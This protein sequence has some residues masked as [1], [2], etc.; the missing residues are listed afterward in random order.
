MSTTDFDVDEVISKATIVEKLKLLAGKDAWHTY[1][2][3]SLGV[4]SIRFT[5]GPNGARGTRFVSGVPA[6]CVPC[7][8][9][10]GATWDQE[11]IYL[12]G[13]L[14]GEEV[15]AK[16]ARGWLGPTV[17]I[18][19]SPLGGR[20]FESFAEDPYLSGKIAASYINGAQSTGIVSTLKHFVANELEHER[21]AVD[22]RVSDRALREIYLLPFQIAIKDASPAAIMTAYNKVN[23]THVSEDSWLL[24]DVLRKDW[25]FKGMIMSDWYGTYSTTE[26][27]NA[28]LD[29]EM[30]GPSRW[31]GDIANLAISSRKITHSTIDAR[32][33][34]VLNLVK[35]C[36]KAEGVSAEEGKRDTPENRALN[37][38]L[39]AEGIV[40]LK[41]D[42]NILPLPDDI[43]EIALI[44][45][46]L[47]NMAYCGGGSAQLEP[48]YIVSNYEGIV[49]QLT[50]QGTRKDVQIHYEIGAHAYDYLPLLGDNVT[51]PSGQKG[52]LQMRFFNEPVSST[53]REIIDELD[54]HDSAW[55]LMGYSSSRLNDRFWADIQGTFTPTETATFQWGIACYGTASL[56]VDDKLVI[57]NT[58]TQRPGNSF[59]GKGTAE[60]RHLIEMVAGKAYKIRVEYGNALTTKV[61][62]PGV[63]NYGGG[64]GRIGAVAI[65]D[66][67][68]AIN[69]AVMLAERCKYTILC[70]GLDKEWE[71][72]GFDRSTMDLP[73]PMP[74]LIQSVLDVNPNTIVVT[75]S[76]T[77]INM[78]PWV[79]TTTTQVH[80]WYGGNEVGNGLAD[81]LFGKVNPSGKL[82]MSFPNA[83]EDTPSFLNFE[84]QRGR[85]IYGEDIYVGYRYYEKLKK[86]LAFPFGHGLS[87]TTFN[88]SNLHVTRQ[89]ATFRIRNSGSTDGATV[90]QLYVSPS[91]SNS[92]SRPVKELKGFIKVFLRRGEEK[93][94][95]IPIDRLATSF[96]DE[97]IGAWV[98]EQGTYGVLVGESSVN[99]C[100]K[101]LL[102]VG[103]T[104]TWSGL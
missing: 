54:L 11:L 43:T 24:E 102:D 65:R 21:M 92:I 9:A 94:V 1:D 104:M 61:L 79:S 56:Y 93:D 13:Q 10:L 89:S 20:G 18:Q 34:N 14:I 22:V 7:G 86:S 60:E 17:N 72:E 44:G 77:P 38:R 67:Q 98:S 95:S 42:N 16:G 76:G 53:N 46:S 4:P 33:R 50:A 82:P 15:K 97:V 37:R 63:V 52:E 68:T 100:L 59:F 25:G 80:M 47:K 29:L 28:G 12:A 30:P 49:D 27:L 90:A 57:D 88:Y 40:L 62:K 96:W 36:M 85:V 6:A 26:A 41:N 101:G 58:S 84:S 31:R 55:Q 23:G 66:S 78:Q 83:I 81:V 39:A 32:A 3:P 5:D 70:V 48:Y 75:Q 71:S 87:F 74:K 103:E 91:P 99:I 19:R 8:T 51:S 35:S 73:D 69:A 64:A 2:I 45:P